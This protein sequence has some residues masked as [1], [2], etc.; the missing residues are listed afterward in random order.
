MSFPL[1][2]KFWSP[3]YEAWLVKYVQPER[4]LPG[5]DTP[6]LSCPVC[7]A[8]IFTS[9]KSKVH[10]SLTQAIYSAHACLIPLFEVL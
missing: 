2:P 4:C 8:A 3:V 5:V 1:W 9:A 6:S 10:F 7:H